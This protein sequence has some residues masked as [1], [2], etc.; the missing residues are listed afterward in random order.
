MELF[1]QAGFTRVLE[2]GEAKPIEEAQLR[3]LK[4]VVMVWLNGTGAGARL[5]GSAGACEQA[6]DTLPGR[7]SARPTQFPR[8]VATGYVR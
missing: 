2:N 5:T 1:Q 6:F 4:G 8:K 3:P 7:A